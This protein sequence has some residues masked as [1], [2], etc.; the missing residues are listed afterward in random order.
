METQFYY[1]PVMISKTQAICS[2]AFDSVRKHPERKC[3]LPRL[4]SWWRLLRNGQKFFHTECV[5]VAYPERRIQGAIEY[6]AGLNGEGRP[7]I[8]VLGKS[9]SS[10]I[11]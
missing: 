3:D 9:E 11:S 5:A 10:G 7:T 1:Q 8:Q 4:I 6:L 2:Q